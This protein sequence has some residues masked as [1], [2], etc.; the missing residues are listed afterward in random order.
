M[1]HRLEYIHYDGPNVHRGQI[2]LPD[3]TPDEFEVGKHMCKVLQV[4]EGD[5]PINPMLYVW[6]V[7]IPEDK[8][9]EQRLIAMGKWKVVNLKKEA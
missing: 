3:V 8:Q 9:E 2:P 7:C 4:P 1:K 6:K 5:H